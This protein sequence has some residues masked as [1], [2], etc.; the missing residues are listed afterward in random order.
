MLEAATG[1]PWTKDMTDAL[2]QRSKLL[3][4][5]ILMRHSG[6][7]REQEVTAVYPS[8]EMPDA[9]GLTVSYEDF[10]KLVDGYY[11]ER[12]WDIETGWPTRETWVKY[13]LDYVADDM[14]KENKLPA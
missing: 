5:A 8:I 4:R 12:G 11:R 1:D 10:N 6:R 2:A 3:F 14:K 7:S 13:G 9:S